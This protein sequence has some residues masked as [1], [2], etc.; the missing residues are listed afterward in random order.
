[1]TRL[2]K[3]LTSNELFVLSASCNQGLGFFKDDA[4]RVLLAARYL[5]KH[6]RE[7]NL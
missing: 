3:P 6:Q 2:V 7:N 5:V 1:M 4:R